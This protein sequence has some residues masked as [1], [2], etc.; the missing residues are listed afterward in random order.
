VIGQIP[1]YKIDFA[2]LKGFIFPSNLHHTTQN[3]WIVKFCTTCSSLTNCKH[4]CATIKWMVF[5]YL[6][7]LTK[8][9]IFLFVSSNLDCT[10]S[11][12][13]SWNQSVNAETEKCYGA[14]NLTETWMLKYT[15]GGKNIWF[16]LISRHFHYLLLTDNSSDSQRLISKSRFITVDSTSSTR[17]QPS[18]ISVNLFTWFLI[19]LVFEVVTAILRFCCRKTQ[20]STDCAISSS[21]GQ[22]LCDD[23]ASWLPTTLFSA[24]D[25][26]TALGRGGKSWE[27]RKRYKKQKHRY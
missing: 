20:P 6:G 24:R 21:S 14:Y 27:H 1:S 15:T 9:S 16:K 3:P 5:W 4:G 13:A 11:S 18:D 26:R 17:F 23:R 19:D 22:S 7:Q 8:C 12:K 10:G 25:A 2:F